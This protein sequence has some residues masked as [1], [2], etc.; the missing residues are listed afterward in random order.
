MRRTEAALG[1]TYPNLANLH[2]RLFFRVL[3]P[4]LSAV[5]HPLRLVALDSDDLWDGQLDRL[6]QPQ[7]LRVS[8]DAGEESFGDIRDSGSSPDLSVFDV[9]IGLLRFDI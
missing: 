5:H 1:T 7:P 6:H 3:H 4:H 8:R 9:Q 2:I